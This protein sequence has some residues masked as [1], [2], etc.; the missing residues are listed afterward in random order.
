MLQLLCVFLPFLVRCHFGFDDF[1][2]PFLRADRAFCTIPPRSM[3]WCRL[4][5][6]NKTDAT[7]VIGAICVNKKKTVHTWSATHRK[8]R[9]KSGELALLPI[10]VRKASL[11]VD[12]FCFEDPWSLHCRLRLQFNYNWMHDFIRTNGIDTNRLVMHYGID[13]LFI[14]VKMVWQPQP[15]AQS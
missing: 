4:H 14:D 2:T 11:F 10:L 9:P 7:G 1:F 12:L 6:R 5:M 3:V 8:S 15:C 13:F